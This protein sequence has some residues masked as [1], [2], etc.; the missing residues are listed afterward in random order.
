MKTLITL[1]IIAVLGFSSAWCV[2]QSPDL[3]VCAGQ[4][5]TINSS[6]AASSDAEGSPEP[7]YVW[8]RD[9]QTIDG[10]TGVTYESSIDTPGEYSFTR[11][12]AAGTCSAATTTPVVVRV[13]AKPGFPQ[14][15]APAAAVEGGDAVFTVPAFIFT[16]GEDAYTSVPVADIANYDFQWTDLG[17]TAN[18]N[19]YTFSGATAGVL[20]A[21]VQVVV[22]SG[23][24]TL[25][26]SASVTVDADAPDTATGATATFTDQR[27][28]KQYKTVVMPD[29]KTW[30]AENLNYITDLIYNENANE[31]NNSTF[32]TTTSGVPAIGSYWCPAAIGSTASGTEAS[33]ITYGALY[34]WETAMSVDGK[35]ADES[36]GIGWSEVSSN[37]F[38]TG[39]SSVTAKA[40]INNGRGGTSVLGGGRGIC[41]PSWHVPTDLEWATLLDA[42]DGA[43]TGTAFRTQTGTGWAGTDAGI[44]MRSAATY[45]DTDPGDGSWRDSA[46]RGNDAAGFGA[47]PAGRRFNN[48]VLIGERGTNVHYWSSSMNSSINAWRREFAY[49]N[50]QVNHNVGARSAGYSVRCVKD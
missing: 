50:T 38:S 5:F 24:R 8:L 42:V 46:N 2:A 29:G 34:T 10:A 49:A 1:S 7:S 14:V 47:V 44:K 13:V 23:C 30:M 40:N 9:E 15:V 43:G 32:T 35:Y 11:V 28:G 3:T 39:A 6:A 45:T 31:A 37:Y 36:Q 33:C 20:T 22:N 25:Q 16:V 41:P 18:G 48:G 27:D 21:E 12:A 26:S 17:G 19:S 4:M